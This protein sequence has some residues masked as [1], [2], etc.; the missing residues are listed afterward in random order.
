M[1]EDTEL[2]LRIAVQVLGR[3]A[4]GYLAAGD[5]RRR[6]VTLERMAAAGDENT[7]AIKIYQSDVEHRLGHPAPSPEK[8]G[9]LKPLIIIGPHRDPRRIS[10]G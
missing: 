10:A 1:D 4:D 5:Y 7:S 9:F 2:R 8:S 3:L 6:A